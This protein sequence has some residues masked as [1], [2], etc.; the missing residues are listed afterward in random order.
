MNLTPLAL[1]LALSYHV[2][3]LPRPLHLLAPYPVPEAE[4]LVHDH[5][6]G[7]R[8]GNRFDHVPSAL[9]TCTM[10]SRTLLALPSP[11]TAQA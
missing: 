4:I 7:L 11:A 6:S 5:I 3:L 10:P 9:A 1:G 8:Y 2:A